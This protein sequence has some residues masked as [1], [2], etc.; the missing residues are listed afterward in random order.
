MEHDE[1]EMEYNPEVGQESSEETPLCSAH[2]NTHEEDIQ[3]TGKS[4]S[5]IDDH[6]L[7]V[8]SMLS[9]YWPGFHGSSNVNIDESGKRTRHKRSHS[10][11]H[12]KTSGDSTPTRKFS[13]AS[14]DR[15]KTTLTSISRISALS[16]N[17]LNASISNIHRCSSA[18]NLFS[19]FSNSQRGVRVSDPGLYI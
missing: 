14:V 10:V 13:V 19:F 5:I 4:N 18:K 3:C 11:H 6:F 16:S 9:G 17:F 1:L 15:H 8:P 7:Q 12:V 2:I